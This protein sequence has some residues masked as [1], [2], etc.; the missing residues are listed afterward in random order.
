MAQGRSPSVSVGAGQGKGVLPAGLSCC[1]ST[2][3]PHDRNSYRPDG[4]FQTTAAKGDEIQD[5]GTGTGCHE[6][7]GLKLRAQFSEDGQ[8]R[9]R[10]TAL[11]TSV[12]A[13]LHLSTPRAAWPRQDAVFPSHLWRAGCKPTQQG[14][15]LLHHMFGKGHV[16]HGATDVL[17]RGCPQLQALLHH[18]PQQHNGL[19]T[20]SL[21]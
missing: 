3:V 12:S 2:A 13:C 15:C 17:C 7:T 1:V 21:P 18:L 5:C 19:E 8:R 16:L 11:G 4:W 10:T 6:G 9:R 14:L 20:P